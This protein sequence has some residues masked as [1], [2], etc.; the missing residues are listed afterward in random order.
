MVKKADRR[1]RKKNIPDTAANQNPAQIIRKRREKLSIKLGYRSLALKAILVAA[2]GVVLFTQVLTVTIASGQGMF[3]SI[4]DGDLVVA[5]R[6]N[7]GY[8]QNDVVVYRQDG[9]RKIGRVAGK[10]Y[11]LV[12]MDDSGSLLVNGVSETG[13][14]LYPTYAKEG[15][16]YPLQLAE[17][18]IFVLGDYRTKSEDSRDYGAILADDVEGKVIT[19]IRRRGL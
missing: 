9:V 8:E 4:K 6:I 18:E 1:A 16:T 3:P 19:V 7:G 12:Y 5:L 15:V 10:S 17:D 11:D 13:E 14:I 2:A